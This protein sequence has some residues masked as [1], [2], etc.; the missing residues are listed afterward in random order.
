MRALPGCARCREDRDVLSTAGRERPKGSRAQL[1]GLREF[2]GALS[3]LLLL[4]IT[5]LGGRG[6]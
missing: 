4:V 3:E 1:D 2:T 5:D 6:L